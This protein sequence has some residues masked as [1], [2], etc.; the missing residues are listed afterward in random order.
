MTRW[1]ISGPIT[2][3]ANTPKRRAAQDAANLQRF[4]A[5]ADEC[6]ELARKAGWLDVEVLELKRGEAPPPGMF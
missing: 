6:A 5:A 4:H 2:S 3:R 1:Y